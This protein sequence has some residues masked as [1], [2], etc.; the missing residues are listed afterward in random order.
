MNG[1]A[2]GTASAKVVGEEAGE[3]LEACVAGAVGGW[4]TGAR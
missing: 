3:Q 4:G 1:E 2:E